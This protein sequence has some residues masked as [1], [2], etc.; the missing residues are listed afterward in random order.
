[1]VV[2]TAGQAEASPFAVTAGDAGRHLPDVR[3]DQPV[4]NSSAE[5]TSGIA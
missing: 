3:A 5:V 4:S 1:M 2:H